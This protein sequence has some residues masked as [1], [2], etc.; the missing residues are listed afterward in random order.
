M[1]HAA[2][3]MIELSER[4]ALAWASATCAGLRPTPAS[5]AAISVA[6]SAT[7]PTD[8]PVGSACVTGLLW[9]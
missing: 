3:R 1:P 9:A 8:R 4:F 6:V 2:D 5:A 7:E